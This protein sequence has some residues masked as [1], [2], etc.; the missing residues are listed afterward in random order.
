MY[1][2]CKYVCVCV[3][4]AYVCFVHV[5]V[6]CMYIVCVCVYVRVHECAWMVILHTYTY[7]SVRRSKYFLESCD[8]FFNAFTQMQLDCKHDTQ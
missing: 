6:V 8:L 7:F 5:C 3:F 4:H 1:A 2:L